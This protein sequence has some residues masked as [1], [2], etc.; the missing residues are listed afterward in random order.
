MDEI[1]RISREYDRTQGD[2]ALRYIAHDIWVYFSALKGEGLSDEDALEIT[3]A[4]QAMMMV[5][6][7]EGGQ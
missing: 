6:Y 5:R 4:W 3:L 1:D 2:E 7:Q